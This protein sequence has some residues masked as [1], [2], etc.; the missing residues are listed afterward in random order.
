MNAGNTFTLGA[1]ETVF[2]YTTAQCYFGDVPDVPAKA[3]RLADGTLMLVAGTTPQNYAMFG[4]DFS[5]LKKDCSTPTL[6][7]HDDPTPQSY[8]NREWIDSV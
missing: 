7:A 3:V 8:Q 1:V 5:S 6:L 4:A 2:T